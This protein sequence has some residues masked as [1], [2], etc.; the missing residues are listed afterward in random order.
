MIIEFTVG[1]FMSIKHKQALSLQAAPIVSKDPEVD[2][3]NVFTA[4][5]GLKLLKSVAIFGPNA[6]GKSN[7]LRA[8]TWMLHFVDK[9]FQDDHLVKDFPIFALD[10]EC[11][12]MPAHFELVFI[13]DGNRYRYGFEITE[14]RVSAEWLFGPAT[15]NE[16]EY[17]TRL[18][19]EIKINK[20]RFKEG[21]ELPPDKTKSSTLFL[22]VVEAFNGPIAAEVKSFFTGRIRINAGV[23]D[24]AFRK[25]TLLMMEEEE[26]RKQIADL[27]RSADMG[28]EDITQVSVDHLEIVEDQQPRLQNKSKEEKPSKV[29]GTVKKIKNEPPGSQ[30]SFFD[31]DNFESEGTKKFFSYSGPII[32]SLQTGIALVVDE[33]DSRLHPTLTRK[34]VELFNS[35]ELNPNNAQLIFVAHD[36]NL[37]DLALLRRDQIYFTEK[38]TDGETSLYSLINIGGVRNDVSYEREY[39]KGKYGALPYLS[40]FK[41]ESHEPDQKDR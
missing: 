34:I 35:K 15:T 14:Q 8:L 18:G 33:L 37:L 6:S 19:D 7:L 10:Q 16:V 3:R 13:T 17:F 39:M 40:K 1:N 4:P 31:F 24:H 26:L 11:E 21:G 23:N 5:G 29:L 30:P 32:Q 2:E 27:M 28:I 22:N 20:S 38:N 41:V 9:S 36:I 25:N 12:K